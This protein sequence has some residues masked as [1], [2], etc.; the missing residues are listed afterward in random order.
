MI[1]CTVL[2]FF[3]H[4]CV[5]LWLPSVS[6]SDWPAEGGW[7]TCM[8][9]ELYQTAAPHVL[10]NRGLKI[11]L[12]TEI[13][14]KINQSTTVTVIQNAAGIFQHDSHCLRKEAQLKTTQCSVRLE[15]FVTELKCSFSHH[16]HHVIQKGNTWWL[17]DIAAVPAWSNVC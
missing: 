11:D 13:I 12:Q 2:I 1:Y 9:P 14:S 4:L 5:L 15:Q 6:W 16:I 17:M 10:Y 3:L 7:I 8:S